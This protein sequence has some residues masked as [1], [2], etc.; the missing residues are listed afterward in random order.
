MQLIAQFVAYSC[1]KKNLIWIE[2]HWMAWRKRE[3]NV[4][5]VETY[6]S[7]FTKWS[8]VA[9][10]HIKCTWALLSQWQRKSYVQRLHKHKTW[11]TSIRR[12]Y[13]NYMEQ[14]NR[15]YWFWHNSLY[16]YDKWLNGM[17]RMY[18]W[19]WVASVLVLSTVTYWMCGIKVEA[20]RENKIT[21]LQP[22][23]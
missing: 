20:L 22:Y 18:A 1:V 12:R 11:T 6:Q 5:T 14:R 15:S 8:E 3:K 21:N 17:L 16:I 23:F 19:N 9:A 13:Y 2:R 10:F 7:W 4:V